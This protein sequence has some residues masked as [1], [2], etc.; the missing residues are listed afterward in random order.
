MTG[1]V[2]AHT[3]AARG[4]RVRNR[5]PDGGATGEGG[6]PT[7]SPTWVDTSGSGAGI[8]CSSRYEY[9]CAGVEYSRSGG[10]TSQIF[11]RYITATRSL[12]FFTTAR[13][14]E[15]N[16]SVRP[17]SAFMSSSRLRMEAWTDTSSADTGSSQM[18]ILGSVMSAR[19]IEM[20]WH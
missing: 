10:A 17:Y 2:C 20:R 5:Q 6:S 19:A 4:H 16:N 12:T 1:S 11:P 13:S 7:T 9:G 3:S 15:M 8:A 18:T 14:W